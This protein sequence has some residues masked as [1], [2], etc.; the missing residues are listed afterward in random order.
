MNHQDKLPVLTLVPPKAD[1]SPRS[2]PAK[3]ANQTRPDA[4]DQAL[5]ALREGEA[6]TP[7]A[8]GADGPSPDPKDGF[9]DVFA[10]LPQPTWRAGSGLDRGSRAKPPATMG[11]S[12]GDLVQTG[13]K[14]DRDRLSRR[15]TAI[16]FPRLAMERWQNWKARQQDHIPEDLPVALAVEGQH[17][18]VIHATNRAAEA[19]GVTR[20]ARVVDM[21]A[22]CPHLKVEF[23]DPEGD[24]IAL[25]RLMLWVRRWCPWSARDGAAG[26]VLDTTGSDHLWGGEASM[27]RTMEEAFSALGLSADLATAPTHG[28]AWALARFGHVRQI[29]PPDHLA[30]MMA[31][32]PAAALRLDGDTVL[33]LK[34]LG[35]K[36]VGQLAAVPRLSLA[37]R[38]S[39]STAAQNPLVRLDQ[40]MGKLAEPVSSPDDPPRF[41]V[42]SKLPEPIEDP[43][44]HLPGLCQS[45]CAMLEAAGFGARRMTLTVYRTDGD[46]SAVSVA[47]ARASRDAGHLARL[48]DGKLDR[49]DPGFGFDLITLAASA[50]EDLAQ[51]QTQLDGRP[52]NAADLAQLL[53]RLTA[54]FGAGAVRAVAPR[55]S[56]I[57][58]R[59]ETWAP[60]M[61]RTLVP[62][63]GRRRPR[64]LRLY[65]RP[66]EVRVLYAVPDG[67]P[68]QFVWRRQTYRVTRFA[69]PERIAP[70]WWAD[71]P[72]TRL[73][74]Y[75]QVE[76][77][78]GLR[79]WMYREGVLEDG[80]GGTPRWFI[81]GVFG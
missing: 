28:A 8:P 64:P 40:M 17:G 44:H 77:H 24:I 61:G 36:T 5:K 10:P 70:E 25:D 42:Q 19:E 6:W 20:G 32:L 4:L 74:D 13:P 31:P 59:Q 46:I 29:C 43:S 56:H 11:R 60:A 23:A 76:T 50:A 81:Q 1:K 67:P 21:R 16:T 45:L 73:R 49:I 30:A 27:L 52:D 58:E 12:G 35:L 39:Q 55:D 34:R 38:F 53:D 7:T 78:T 54:R 65:D 18:P 75:Y 41:S 15:I 79:V 51:A 57:P 62:A 71:L 66:D 9:T 22:L 48:F 2:E 14:L 72:G 63:N 33:L 68:A 47:T 3:P 80:R 37:R 26:L 69:G